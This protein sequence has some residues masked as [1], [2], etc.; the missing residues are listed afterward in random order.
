MHKKRK[1]G[2]QEEQGPLSTLGG[3]FRFGKM[4]SG[5]GDCGLLRPP[6]AKLC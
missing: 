4:E 3:P 2:K 6:W 5:S 1:V